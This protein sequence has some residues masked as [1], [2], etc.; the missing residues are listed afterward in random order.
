MAPH[1]PGESKAKSGTSRGRSTTWD[2]LQRVRSLYQFFI[3]KHIGFYWS[4]IVFMGFS[5]DV[6][7]VRL[8]RRTPRLKISRRMLHQRLKC[9]GSK[10]RWVRMNKS[11]ACFTGAVNQGRCAKASWRTVVRSWSKRNETNGWSFGDRP[12]RSAARCKVT[13][14]PNIQNC[15]TLES[16]NGEPVLE[17]Y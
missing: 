4:F 5:S 15:S 8:S 6:L 16:A 13:T 12:R 7:C 10:G 17:L 9:Q 2:E 14:L 3:A 1:S 11:A